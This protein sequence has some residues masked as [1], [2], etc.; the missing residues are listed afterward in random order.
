MGLNNVEKQKYSDNHN[1]LSSD[2]HFVMYNSLGLIS[3]AS[4]SSS[5]PGQE[6]LNLVLILLG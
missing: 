3:C 2:E 5:K 1:K 4:N 6:S